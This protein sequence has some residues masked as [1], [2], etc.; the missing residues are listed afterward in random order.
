MKI[1]LTGSSSGIGQATKELLQ[2]NHEVVAPFRSDFDLEDFQCIENTDFSSYDVIVNCAGANMGAW[3]GWHKNSW[4]NQSRH[5]A[6]NFTAPLLMAKQ[7]TQQRSHGH[8]VYVTSASADDPIAYNIFMVA[9]KAALRYSIDAVKKD[10]PNFIFTEI[11]PGKTRS[12]M[13]KQNY[14]HHKT[15]QEIEHMYQ[16]ET[17]LSSEQVAQAIATAMEQRLDKITILPHSV[18]K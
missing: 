14:Q 9:G 2:N 4:Q 15:A 17:C 1:F 13:L 11:C 10:Y 6:V 8:F 5:V 3:Q 7:Y 12:N 16:Q 18:V